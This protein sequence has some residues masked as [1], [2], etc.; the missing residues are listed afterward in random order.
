MKKY[1]I[2]NWWRYTL[3]GISLICSTAIDVLLPFVTLSMVD[4]VIV[5]RNMEKTLTEE[6]TEEKAE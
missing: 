2:R 4:D 3:G 1:L 6:K 5:G